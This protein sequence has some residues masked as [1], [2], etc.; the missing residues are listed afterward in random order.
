MRVL[1]DNLAEEL[2]TLLKDWSVSSVDIA[3]AWATEGR[4][5]DALADLQRR[6]KRKLSVRTL[7]GYSGNHTTPAA[8]ERLSKFGEV[9]LVNDKAGLFHVKLL[10]FRSSRKSLAWVGSA[11][12]TGPG[13][14]GNEELIYETEDTQELKDWFDKR[15]EKVGPQH[16]EL[17][18]Y[19][20]EWKRPAVP[21]RGVTGGRVRN[22]SSTPN[23]SSRRVTA[24]RTIV[25]FE[26]EGVR[27]TPYTGKGQKRQSPRGRITIGNKHY[28]YDSAIGCLKIVLEDLAQR[29]SGFLKRCWDDPRF[30]TRGRRTHYIARSRSDLGSE[31]FG[32]SAKELNSGWWLAGQTQTQRKWQLICAAADIAGLRVRV[33]GTMWQAEG[34]LGA[35]KVGF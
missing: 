29:D 26:Q 14:D 7:A 19:R 31:H 17:A 11:N 3:T 23:Q 6:R 32:I 15:W 1:A 4:A 9:R 30:H 35:N 5:L 27:P 16:N 21:L 28:P 2:V 13:F 20:K 24:K 22:S 33:K 8:L 25:V 10:I 18:K 34:Q 12:F